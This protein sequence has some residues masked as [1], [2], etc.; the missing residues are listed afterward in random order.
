MFIA[1]LML[2]SNWLKRIT[3]VRK[4]EGDIYCSHM[5]SIR[6]FFS[7]MCDI[8]STRGVSPRYPGI[9]LHGIGTWPHPLALAYCLCPT[10]HGIG[11]QSPR[12]RSEIDWSGRKGTERTEPLHQMH[13]YMRSRV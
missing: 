9:R 4:Q 13:H 2:P 5:K 8:L 10:H 12:I 3:C 11:S 6:R 1:K 7:V